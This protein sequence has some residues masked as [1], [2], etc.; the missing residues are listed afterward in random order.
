MKRAYCGKVAVSRRQ[1]ALGV[2]VEHEHTKSA[3][4]A[5]R[6][7]CDHLLEFGGAPYY[8]ELTK[9]EKRLKRMTRR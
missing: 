8:T 7:A 4:V 9:M 3:K 6:I 2:K 5:R 1:L